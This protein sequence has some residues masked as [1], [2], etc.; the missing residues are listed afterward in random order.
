MKTNKINVLL[1][2][3]KTTVAGYAGNTTNGNEAIIRASGAACAGGCGLEQTVGGGGGN[4]AGG[5]T[6]D[7]LIKFV[8][9]K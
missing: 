2:L 6:G 9:K 3:N 5:D 7:L 8:V 1:S 4:S